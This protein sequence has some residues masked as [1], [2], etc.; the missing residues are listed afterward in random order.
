MTAQT[1]TMDGNHAVTH[2]AYRVNE[3][4]SIFPITPSSP[5]AEMSDTWTAQGLKN[6]WGNVPLVQEMQAEGG[7]RDRVRSAHR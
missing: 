3:V 1:A 4:M 5:M 7:A 2:I 6:I